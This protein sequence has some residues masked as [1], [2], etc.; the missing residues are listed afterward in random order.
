M[1][2]YEIPVLHRVGEQICSVD[3]DLE[4]FNKSVQHISKDVSL[5]VFLVSTWKSPLVNYWIL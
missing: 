3:A 4:I 5:M 2:C 1:L